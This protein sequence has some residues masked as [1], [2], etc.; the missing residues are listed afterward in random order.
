MCLLLLAKNF[1]PVYKFIIA[2]NRD[3]FLERPTEPVKFWENYNLIAGK[4]IKAG[5]TWLGMTREGKFAAITNYRSP[6]EMKN[7][8]P[9]RGHIVSDFLINNYDTGD[10]SKILLESAEKYNG[11]NLIFGN[12]QE[13]YYFSNKTK[14]IIKL[15]EGVFGL[16]NHLLD[17]PW[18]KV[19]KSKSALQILLKSQNITADDLFKILIDDAQAEDED[20]PDTG[21]G[22]E[23]ERAV[24]PI[25]INT[26][27]YGT[28]SQ[29][30]IMVDRQNNVKF[31]ERA[32][33]VE[34]RE[35][36]ERPFHF[37]IKEK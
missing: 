37:R 35:W 25:F 28:R 1:H 32:L 8:A 34:K 3:E 16:S 12:L 30:I 15:N 23:I 26:P 14:E 33:D 21:V 6:L 17:T 22:I 31:I 11:Y 4:D 27:Q 9:S 20:L 13:L 29:T 7:D 5:G 10:Y 19:E 36:K 18:P 24:S 2:A